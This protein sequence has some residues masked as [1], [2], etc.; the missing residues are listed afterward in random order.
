M[1]NWE[2]EEIQIVI[3]DAPIIPRFLY[4]VLLGFCI[5]NAVIVCFDPA[6]FSQVLIRN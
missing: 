1:I 3:R 5:M 2:I 6:S 4:H